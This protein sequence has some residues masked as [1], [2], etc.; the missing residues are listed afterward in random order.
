MDGSA[1]TERAQSK[2]AAIIVIGD[3]I[4]KGAVIENGMFAGLTKKCEGN[5]ETEGACH[6]K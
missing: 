3:E 4:L 1:A 6:F 2:T 5:S